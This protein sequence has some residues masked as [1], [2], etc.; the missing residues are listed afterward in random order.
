MRVYCVVVFFFLTYVYAHTHTVL[1]ANFV[2]VATN[3]DNNT[4]RGRVYVLSA[5]IICNLY[6]RGEIPVE[7][8]AVPPRPHVWNAFSF[9]RYPVVRDL[10]FDNNVHGEC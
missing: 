9:R 2:L 7:K 1:L 10:S 4:Y 3:F 8:Q 6:V 5:S